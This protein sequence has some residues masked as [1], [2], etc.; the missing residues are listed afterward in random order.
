MCVK[1]FIN[2]LYGKFGEK[3]HPLRILM[4]KE[5]HDDEDKF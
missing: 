5:V 4:N 1:V 2:S 3:I